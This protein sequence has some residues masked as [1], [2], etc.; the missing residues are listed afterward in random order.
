MSE[1]FSTAKSG[2]RVGPYGAYIAGLGWSLPKRIVTNR[3]VTEG[4]IPFLDPPES[5]N[6]EA[7]KP[8]DEKW[9][10]K[11]AG[12][13]YRRWMS[14]GEKLYN[15]SA[16]ACERALAAAGCSFGDID[17]IIV[18]TVTPEDHWPSEAAWVTHAF[19]DPKISGHDVTAA[20]SSFMYALEQGYMAIRS[21]M[22][23]K[24][25]VVGADA[26][27]RAANPRDRSS[28]MLF[29]DAAAAVVLMADDPSRDCFLYWSTGQD[30]SGIDLIGSKVVPE[31]VNYPDS[32][33]S[34]GLRRVWM[35]GPKVYEVIVPMASGLIADALD[36]AGLKA[37]DIAA[38][39]MHQANDRMTTAICRS[40]GFK[41]E[42]VIRNIQ[43]F[44]NTTS[45]AVPL[46]LGEAFARNLHD[47]SL[48]EI[49]AGDP[50]LLFAFGGGLTWSLTIIKWSDK[51]P[52]AKSVPW[53]AEQA[54][55]LFRV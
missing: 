46:A 7:G 50:V 9:V 17:R 53:A 24:V 10:R 42:R 36:K 29:G 21:G 26:M 2:T 49:K 16:K 51:H 34:L 43:R 4:M 13:E 6:I 40:V 30:T 54:K 11:A 25:L 32:A 19:G 12:V 55:E 33:V 52:A 1:V 35:N 41:P 8:T 20:C 37:D 39:C 14:D 5:V 47:S 27:A 38:V 23:Q 3:E 31:A 28:F 45:A 48:P 44:G 18:G 15:F 22:S